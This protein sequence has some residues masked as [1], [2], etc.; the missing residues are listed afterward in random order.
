MSP[1]EVVK[2]RQKI[3]VSPF[4]FHRLIVKNIGKVAGKEVR[5]LLTYVKVPEN[6]I[7]VPLDWT[8][9]KTNSRD[10]SRGEPA[11][12]DVL[13]KKEN[14]TQYEFCLPVEI[15]GT[16]EK[17][18]KEFNPKYGNIRLELLNVTGRLEILHSG[19][20]VIQIN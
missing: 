11:Y 18:L 6:F 19:T 9:W 4:I 3:G 17:I 8:H 7:S 5:V 14:A 20:W 13:H 16:S 2:T 15:Q 12:I 10:I 1:V